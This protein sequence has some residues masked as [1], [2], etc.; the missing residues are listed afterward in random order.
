[1]DILVLTATGDKTASRGVQMI[2]NNYFNDAFF[3]KTL[4]M[5]E[6]IIYLLYYITYIKQRTLLL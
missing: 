2:H 4:G 3:L 6:L 1:M 5:F